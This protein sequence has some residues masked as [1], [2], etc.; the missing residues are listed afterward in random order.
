MRI[1]ERGLVPA[2]VSEVGFFERRTALDVNASSTA[3][4]KH[5]LRAE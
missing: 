4:L 3:M 2:R 1:S 5:R